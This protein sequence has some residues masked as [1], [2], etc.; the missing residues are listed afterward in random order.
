VSLVTRGRQL[1]LLSYSGR[2]MPIY[3]ISCGKCGFKEERLFQNQREFENHKCPTCGIHKWV[4]KPS[5]VAW[6]LGKKFLQKDAAS[7]TA[8]MGYGKPT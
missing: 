2:N 8:E 6:F 3:D 5:R 7:Q 1:P 4:K